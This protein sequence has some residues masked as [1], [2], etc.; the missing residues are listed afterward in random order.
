M[1]VPLFERHGDVFAVLTVR[2]DDL[3]RHAGEISFPGGRRDAD[4][5]SLTDTALREAREEIGLEPESVRLLGELPSVSTFATGYV[6]QPVIGAIA[7]GTQWTPAQAE[8]AA[9]LEL[10]LHS[11]EAGR[12]PVELERR[13][14]RFWTEA[15]T[16]DGHVIWGATARILSHLFERIES[17]PALDL[18][19]P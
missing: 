11:I 17:G 9:V 19:A 2:R 4:D 1:L 8:V 7:D 18:G 14:F 3:R 5:A 13:G 10:S 6:I 12:A 16:V 15:F